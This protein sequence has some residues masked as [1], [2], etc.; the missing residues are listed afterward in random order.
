MSGEPGYVRWTPSEWQRVAAHSLRHL[1]KGLQLAQALMKAQVSALP[2]E[3]RRDEETL[4]KS[5]YPSSSSA[6]KYIAE[7]RALPK[8]ELEAIA[9]PP[10]PRKPPA[11]RVKLDEGR[12]YSRP[13]H[14]IKWTTLEKARVARQVKAWQDAG[15]QRALSRLIIEAQELVLDAD[16]R[17]PIGSIHVGAAKKTNDRLMVDGLANQWLIKDEPAAPPPRAEPEPE[18]QAQE[19]AQESAAPVLA[20]TPP[21]PERSRLSEAAR[22]FGDT[23]MSAL[24]VLLRVH[25]EELLRGVEARVA[26]VAQ[27]IGLSVAAQIERGMRDTVH[28]IVE[29]EL[30]GPVAS[31]T[32]TGET[33]PPVLGGKTAFE[34]IDPALVEPKPARLRVDVVGLVGN[35]IDEVRRAFNGTTDLRFIDPDQLNA[36]APHRG[37]HVVCAVKWIPHKAKSKLRSV[38]MKPI[39]V[40]GSVGTVIHAIEELHRS[41]GVPV[42]SMEH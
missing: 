18:P 11:P 36:W 8:E 15:D 26:T 38:G 5:A 25:T 10:A 1:D 19:T 29:L 13:G 42:H 40:T 6:A 22:V 41:A 31:P 32:P 9:P 30:G 28:K 23:V 37:R 4:R 39:N 27:E 12:D 3:R 24:D 34:F 7:A 16:R 21:A 17:R 2:K 33:P 20:T 14:L 35:N